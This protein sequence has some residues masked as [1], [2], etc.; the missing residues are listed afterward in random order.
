MTKQTY[1]LA[2]LANG[3]FILVQ[4]GQR[5]AL[6]GGAEFTEADVRIEL[7]RIVSVKDIDVHI[8][9]AKKKTCGIFLGCA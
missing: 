5:P 4:D 2:Y 1:R 8:A 3:N 6:T 7:S 9:A